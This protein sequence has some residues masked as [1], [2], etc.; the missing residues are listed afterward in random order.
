MRVTTAMREAIVEG[1]LD[2]QCIESDHDICPH[3]GACRDCASG[4][5][6]DDDE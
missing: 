3:C 1:G 5:G 4:C 2:E 6:C